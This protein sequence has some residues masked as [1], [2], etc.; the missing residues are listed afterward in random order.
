MIRRYV[1]LWF[2]A[3]GDKPSGRTWAKQLG[4]SCTWLWKLVREFRKDPSDMWRMQAAEV[5]PRLTDL[6]AA[7]QRSRELRQR[8]ELRPLRYRWPRRRRHKTSS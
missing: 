6:V 2:T 8:G 5:D 7:Q 3:A 1:F 4:I